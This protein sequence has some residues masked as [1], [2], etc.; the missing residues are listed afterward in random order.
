MVTGDL[1][2]EKI[3]QKL[4]E[5]NVKNVKMLVFRCKKL[6]E[7]RNDVKRLL[8]ILLQ[9]QMYL[10]NLMSELEQENTPEDMQEMAEDTI[11]LLH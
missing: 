3:L 11:Q 4:E 9:K 2:L 7:A 1:P 6:Y 10:E 5:V 8:T